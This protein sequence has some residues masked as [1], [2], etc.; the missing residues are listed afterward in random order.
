VYL[1]NP[2]PV[3]DE[4]VVTGAI[5]LIYSGLRNVLAEDVSLGFG[6]RLPHLENLIKRCPRQFDGIHLSRKRTRRQSLR[7]V[8]GGSRTSQDTKYRRILSPI[9]QNRKTI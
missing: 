6:K 8:L 9:I 7:L 1:A 4:D 2:F 3:R 5:N